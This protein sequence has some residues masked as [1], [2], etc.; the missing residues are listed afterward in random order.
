[1]S[2]C[3]SLLAS[4]S[5]DRSMPP[6]IVLRFQRFDADLL[7]IRAKLSNPLDPELGLSRPALHT[8]D[9]SGLQLRSAGTIDLCPCRRDVNRVRQLGD[10]ID[11]NLS[12]YTIFL[13]GD[14]RLFRI[15]MDSLALMNRMRNTPATG[16]V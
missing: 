14:L 10:P 1:M 3:V 8:Y 7:F 4:K 16:T 5:S 12:R 6:K 15:G 2:V 9:G 11:R 13:R